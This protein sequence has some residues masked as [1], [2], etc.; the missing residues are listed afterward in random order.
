MSKRNPI[1]LMR[2]ELGASRE[3]KI[4][5]QFGTSQMFRSMVADS[6][7]EEDYKQL[8]DEINELLERFVKKMDNTM[9]RECDN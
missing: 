2:V 4:G 9:E 1:E 5:S 7:M 6:N 8:Q 3:G